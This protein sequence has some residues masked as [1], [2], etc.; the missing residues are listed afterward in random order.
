MAH[1]GDYC[2][3]SIIYC[4]DCPPPLVVEHEG[5][6]I[7]NP[8]AQ[9]ARDKSKDLEPQELASRE[10]HDETIMQV[11]GN[12]NR[13]EGAGFYHQCGAGQHQL[14]VFAAPVMDDMRPFSKP[15]PFYDRY[16]GASFDLGVLGSGNQESKKKPLICRLCLKPVRCLTLKHVERYEA[17]DENRPAAA[18]AP[19]PPQAI[20]DA[21]QMPGV[22]ASAGAAI[23][24]MPFAAAQPPMPQMPPMSVTPS[25]M[26]AQTP[27]PSPV[28]PAGMTGAGADMGAAAAA[29]GGG[30]PCRIGLGDGSNMVVGEMPGSK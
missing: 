27:M 3:I 25:Q 22:P 26:M 8:A 1:K 18:P 29:M 5:H 12:L 9:E 16:G 7:F 30:I 17:C 24:S 10:K 23:P 4:P 21:S 19:I 13:M 28:A 20:P 6:S 15:E 2:T 11:L 14:Q